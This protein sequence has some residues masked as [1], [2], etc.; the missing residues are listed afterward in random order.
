MSGLALVAHALGAR[1]TGSDRAAGSPYAGALRAAGIEPA[2]ATTPR[3]CPHGA[4]VVVSTAIPPDNPE[5]A[6]ARE[7]GLRELHRADLLGELT[8]LRPTIAVTG[9]H[10][11]TTTSS[12]IVHALR[13]CGMDP[14]YLVGGE[15]RSTGHQ[16]RLG[17]RAVA[18]RRGRR[19][20]PLAAQARARRS[21][22]SPTPSSTTTRPTPRSATSTTTFRAFLGARRPRRRRLG[23]A[24]AARA[25][26]RRAPARALRR[27]RRADRRRLA[28]HARRRRGRAGRPRPPQ[29]AQRRGRARPPRGS[30]APTRPP[31]AA[32]LRDFKGAGRR[33]ERLGRH[34]A[35]AEVV[36]DYA[37]HPTEVRRDARGRAHARARARRR[38]LP[39]APVLAHRSARR[40][41]F[42]AALAARRRRRRARRLPG[43]RARRGLPG[44][45]RPARRRGRGRR[46]RRAAGRVAAAL[47][48]AEAYLRGAAR[49]RPRA[50]ARRGRRRRA[51]PRARGGRRAGRRQAERR[52]H[53]ARQRRAGAPDADSRIRWPASQTGSPWRVLAGTLPLAPRRL[54]ARLAAGSATRRFAAVRD[55]VDHRQRLLEEGAGP[56]GAARRPRTG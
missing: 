20:R 38:G 16:R 52:V 28:L 27:R 39:A 17:R 19:V 13:G 15:V 10:G 44:R 9:T 49:R 46:G 41:E 1:V 40:R 47:D 21:R 54:G 26:A 29:R 55:V 23:P 2:S 24:R 33:F 45:D 8:R 48:A 35:G 56:R 3:T 6:A 31:A 25:R 34:A 12:M 36:D 42:G 43:P 4:E 14:A 7:R 22:C 51:R 11:K 5:R 50:H 37:H 32:S 18:R 53:E 30:P